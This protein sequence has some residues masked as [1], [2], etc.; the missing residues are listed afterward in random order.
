MPLVGVV[1]GAGVAGGSCAISTGAPAG[2]KRAGS[3]APPLV[4]ASF[5]GIPLSRN[6]EPDGGAGKE[7]LFAAFVP[8]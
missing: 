5:T 6:D 8:A 3:A 2:T 4:V 7:V 1:P